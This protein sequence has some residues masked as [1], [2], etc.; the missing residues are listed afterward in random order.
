MA[1]IDAKLQ[2]ARTERV[3]AETESQ[4]RLSELRH[5]L[6]TSRQES[7]QQTERLAANV[8]PEKAK[9]SEARESQKDAEGRLSASQ[10]QLTLLQADL[11]SAL[12]TKHSLHQQIARLTSQMTAVEGGKADVSGQLAAMHRTHSELLVRHDDVRSKLANLESA[13]QESADTLAEVTTAKVSAEKE[14]RQIAGRMKFQ[15]AEVKTL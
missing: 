4:S 5:T 12:T 6:D 8:E 7:Q 14:A 2:A 13:G 3:E 1:D 15:E 11:A 10:K 9:T